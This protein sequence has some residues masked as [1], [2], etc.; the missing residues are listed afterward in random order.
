MSTRRGGG[1]GENLAGIIWLPGAVFQ[2]PSFKEANRISRA[3]ESDIVFS[4]FVCSKSLRLE[5][6]VIAVFVSLLRA[7]ANG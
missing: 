6:H 3:G 7:L 4:R 1:R 2:H 5:Q